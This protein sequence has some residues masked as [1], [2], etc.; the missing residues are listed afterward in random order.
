M[1][2]EKAFEIMKSGENVFLTGS[3]GTGKTF[4][5][6]SF[7]N[8]LKK[9]KVHFGIT[10]STGIAATH[11]GGKTI[12]SWAG[13]GLSK[14]INDPYIKKFL[15]RRN[16]QWK[17]IKSSQVLIIDEIS[18]LD[19]KR[20]SLIDKIC[21]IIKEP[22]LPFGG[23]QIIAS[24]DFFQLPP[25]NDDINERAQFCYSS[26]A[27]EKAHFK[28]CYLE[29]QHRQK[30]EQLSKIL[31][32]IRSGLV[33]EKIIDKLK[34][35]INKDVEGLEKITKL[36]THNIDVDRIN[37]LELSKINNPLFEYTMTSTGN[38]K[39]VDFLKK[40]CL[41]PERLKLK[42]DSIVMFVK[43]NPNEG[44]V[45]GTLGKIIGF[46]SNNFPIVKTIDNREII[47]SKLKWDFER[48]GQVV[49]SICQFPLRL[50]WAITIHKSQGMTL[51]AAEIDLTKS[52]E[53]GMGYVALSR[54]KKLNNIKLIG[55]NETALK[56]N[57][58]VQEKDKEFIFLSK[59][60]EKN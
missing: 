39:V 14:D 10:A 37:D 48:E 36:Y 19:A 17:E 38:K 34:G 1:D 21:K 52:F 33:D 6:N 22:F 4:L 31:N 20:L 2:Q 43:N 16:P 9:N 30:D 24:G 56:V 54:V 27:W 46:D 53:A 23:L 15:S 3:A 44:Y 12:H 51:D 45:N 32:N 49:A 59:E 41:A 5:L 47:V 29:E 35:R 42:K 60:N 58:E 28:V 55:I 8:H 50:A 25:I 7:I 18:M 13:I 11:I 40:N 57:K 26:S